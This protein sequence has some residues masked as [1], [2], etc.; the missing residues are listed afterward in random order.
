MFWLSVRSLNVTPLTGS[1]MLICRLETYLWC[2]L[3]LVGFLLIEH[4]RYKSLKIGCHLFDVSLYPSNLEQ[5]DLLFHVSWTSQVWLPYLC[6]RSSAWKM[7]VNCELL[8]L[9]ADIQSFYLCE[10]LTRLTLP[11]LSLGRREELGC[12]AGRLLKGAQRTLKKLH[13]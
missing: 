10:L 2:T 3:K 4:L 7:V 9:L 6:G 11:A 1:Y 8:L 12:G 13:L 5:C